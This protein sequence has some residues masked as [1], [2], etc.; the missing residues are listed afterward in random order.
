[1]QMTYDAWLVALSLV[2][3]ILVSHIAPRLAGRVS[4]AQRR[5][6]RLWLLG[7]GVSLGVGIW[8]AHTASSP[9]TAERRRWSPGR[10]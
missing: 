9:L 5:A 1:M 2:V 4:G 10:R 7:G 6:A 3:V 8:R